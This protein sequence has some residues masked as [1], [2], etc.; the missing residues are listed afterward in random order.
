MPWASASRSHGRKQPLPAAKAGPERGTRRV[1]AKVALDGAQQ[2]P[3]S[4]GAAKLRAE[5]ARLPE[6]VRSMMQAM[7]EGGSREVADRVRARQAEEQ[8]QQQEKQAQEI[9]AAAEK[10][11][12]DERLAK[13]K[14]AAEEKLAREKR[15]ADV[16]L[17]RER[18][19]EQLDHVGALVGREGKTRHRVEFG[20]SRGAWG[21]M[22]TSINTLIDDLLWP[23]TEVT[24]AISA[25]A[26]GDLLQTVPLEVD[27]RSLEG[28]PGQAEPLV[29]ILNERAARRFF[30]D[31][32]LPI[33]RQLM[34]GAPGSDAPWREVIGIV[35]DVRY[36]TVDSTARPDAYISYGQ[37]RL[38]RMMLFVRTAGDPSS[39]TPTDSAPAYRLHITEQPGHS[40]EQA[41]CLGDAHDSL[42][43]SC[44]GHCDDQVG[45]NPVLRDRRWVGRLVLGY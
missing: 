20:L 36:G 14:A 37:A 32:D 31:D 11:A 45:Q 26:Q 28:D 30:P 38:S 29:V 27:G 5:A 3:S 25:V 4:D 41:S 17:T 8:K 43:P 2:P 42:H 21:G 9:R 34:L 15:V 6:P 19:A 22:E 40:I 23:T 44:S 24:R 33:G 7:L 12:A 1:V 39:D 35:G 18:M 16:R 13:E 10:A